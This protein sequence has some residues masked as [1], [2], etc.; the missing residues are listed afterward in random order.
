MI[1]LLA[2]LAAAAEPPVCDLSALEDPGDTLS[3]AWVS[4]L[5][6]RARN[7]EWLYV[8]PTRDLRTFLET[9]AR[10]DL[11]RTLQWL[12]LRRSAKAPKARYKVVVFDVA[13][14]QLCRPVLTTEPAVAGVRPCDEDHAGPQ[15]DYS[16]CGY[17]TDL[18]SERAGGVVY[19]AQWQALA[20]DGFCLLPIERFLN[21][22]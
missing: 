20:A 6:D 5:G 22:D 21:P 8:V 14:D 3:V 19:R 12:G 4:R 18:G 16:G 10:G 15:G 9:E 11:V 7:T 17:L 13:R 1:A 2:R